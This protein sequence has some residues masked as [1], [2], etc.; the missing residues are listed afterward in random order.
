[1]LTQKR[2]KEVLKYNKNTGIFTKGGKSIGYDDGRGYLRT[3]IDGKQYRLHRLAWLYQHG[4]FPDNSLDIDHIN[5][6]KRDNSIDNLRVVS[7]IENSRNQKK[8]STNTSGVS[9][10]YKFGKKWRAM[11]R[12]KDK[13]IHLGLFKEKE[14]ASIA[15]KK[16]LDKYRFHENHGKKE[17]L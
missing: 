4:T 3:L 15:R 1:M 7:H 8:H 11:I 13:L 12:F 10:V 5:Q 9:G 14:D 17:V 2:L 16:A 6:N